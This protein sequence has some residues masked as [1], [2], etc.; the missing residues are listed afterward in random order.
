M[1]SAAHVITLVC[2]AMLWR[3]QFLC[4]V[5]ATKMRQAPTENNIKC[6]KYIW[7]RRHSSELLSNNMYE[8]SAVTKLSR[9]WIGDSPKVSMRYLWNQF[10]STLHSMSLDSTYWLISPGSSHRMQLPRTVPWVWMPLRE[11]PGTGLCSCSVGGHWHQTLVQPLAGQT[12]T[13]ANTYW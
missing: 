3:R 7:A 1:W 6:T 4:C 2:I 5:Q 11:Q 13:L 9:S 10:L 12:N 8:I